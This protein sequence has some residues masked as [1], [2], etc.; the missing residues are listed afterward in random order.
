M[1]RQ[2]EL[3]AL[4]AGASVLEVFL[5]GSVYKHLR[6]GVGDGGS[7]GGASDL[8]AA[9]CMHAWAQ[10]SSLMHLRRTGYRQGT[11]GTQA[12][13]ALGALRLGMGKRDAMVRRGERLST[14][15]CWRLQGK[16]RIRRLAAR[17]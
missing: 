3:R 10:D 2:R 1:A 11:Q 12:L 9:A 5:T 17:T 14:G 7:G 16:V 15:T 8:R 6:L 4:G 13:R